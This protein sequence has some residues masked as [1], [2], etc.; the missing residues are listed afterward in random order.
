[1]KVTYFHR[2]PEKYGS[3][4]LE[5]IFK[6][7]RTRLGDKIEFVIAE[8]KYT[9]K[10]L[11][12][13]V[14]NALEAIF[15]QKG[16]VNHI[17]GDTHYVGIFLKKRKTILTVLDCGFMKQDRSALSKLVYQL[18]WLK[19]PVQNARF[20]TAISKATKDDVVAYTGCKPEKVII[21]PVAIS[22]AYQPHPKPF[23]KIKPIL[24]HIGTNPNKNLLRLIEALNGISC[25]LNIVGKLSEEQVVK[26]QQYSIE[27]SNVFNISD[28]E[29]VQQYINCDVLVYASTYEGF[30][31]PIIEANSIERP[32]LTG[33]VTSMPDVAN[34]AA[35]LVDPFDVNAIREGLLKI[36]QDDVY[37]EQLLENGR[38]NKLR[39]DADYI[40]NLYYELYQKIV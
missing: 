18:F 30:G 22:F 39:F 28:S 16:V 38:K 29:M 14:Y 3:F 13:R 32:V 33:N 19:L 31:M 8:S 21:I 35:C 10:G 27:Y 40:A 12:P 17:T 7:V 24:L 37:R 34:N 20:V 6:D 9:S 15:R 1:M 2:K 26:L 25:H 11:Y 5:Y 23:N 4:S 36:I